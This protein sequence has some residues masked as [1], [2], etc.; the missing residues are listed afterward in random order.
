MTQREASMASKG[1]SVDALRE[2]SL[3]AQL[4]ERGA[5]T[6]IMLRGFIGPSARDGYVRLYPKLQNL[7]D[8]VE[9]A[10]SDIVHSVEAPQSA[11]GAVILWVKKDAKMS[12]HRVGVSESMP[13]PAERL[14]TFNKR[15]AGSSENMVERRRGR[16]RMRLRP[17][18]AQTLCFSHCMDCI[19][20][21]DCS[22]CESHCLGPIYQ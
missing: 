14:A 2:N 7:S 13:A 4:I 21:C 20:W 18:Q 17:Q 19:S 11:L 6:S 3:V 22:T 15:A 12:L 9:I 5:D 1:G 8:S 10:R 16:L